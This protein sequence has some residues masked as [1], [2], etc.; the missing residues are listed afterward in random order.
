MAMVFTDGDVWG[1]NVKE[2]VNFF[3]FLFFLSRFF[4]FKKF[5]VLEKIIE[6]KNDEAPKISAKSVLRKERLQ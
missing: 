2:N 3:Q 1:Q 4:K 5:K 6:E